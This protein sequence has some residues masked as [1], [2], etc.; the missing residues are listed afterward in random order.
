MKKFYDTNVLLN[1]LAK[2]FEEHFICSSKTLE[3]IENIKVSSK[4]EEV[5]YKARKLSK[6]FNENEDYDVIIGNYKDSLKQLEEFGLKETPDNLIMLDAYNCK[7]IVFYTEDICCKNIAKNIFGLNVCSIK[8]DRDDEYKGFKEVTLTDDELAYFY[9]HLDINQFDLFE[10]EYLI[11]KNENDT[12][13]DKFVFKD[14]IYDVVKYHNFKSM[15]LD[16][17]KP[18]DEIQSFAMES[19]V[20]NDITLLYGKAGSGKTTLP[21][22]YIMQE[23]DK[24]KYK[25]CYVIFSFDTLKGAKTLGFEKGSHLEKILATGSI[26]NIL[27]SKLGDICQIERLIEDGLLEIVPTANI[28][29]VEYPKN[30]IVYVTECQNLDV[31]TLKT[32]IQRCQE[33]CKQIYEGDILEQKDV[34]MI[35]NGMQRMIEVFKG[36]ERFGCIKL[37]NN[38][39]SAFCELADMM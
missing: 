3:E 14:G 33:G 5:K 29:G 8:D 38:Y 4:D 31:Y 22:S 18:K 2:A 36:S 9:S 1:L 37:K 32:I 15:Y 6:L 28:R 21:L 34:N 16:T 25:K 35:S 11:I 26:G 24:G 30:S 12:I 10:N 23:L 39:R 27:A 17:I 7:D 20:R 19:I 13:I